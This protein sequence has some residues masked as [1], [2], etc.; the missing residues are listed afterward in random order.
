MGKSV[1]FRYPPRPHFIDEQNIQLRK[2]LS[3]PRQN[4]SNKLLVKPQY[5]QINQGKNK[6]RRV[7]ID[8]FK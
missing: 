3:K 6:N 4:K 7:K 8:K 2:T 5:V 1:R